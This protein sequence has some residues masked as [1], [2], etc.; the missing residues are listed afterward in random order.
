[1]NVRQRSP[2]PRIWL[3]L[4][5]VLLLAATHAPGV[6]A[7][8]IPERTGHTYLAVIEGATPFTTGVAVS[9]AAV[10]HTP[11]G[12]YHGQAG[13]NEFSSD[14]RSSFSDLTFVVR[15]SSVSGDEIVIHFVMTGT[16]T[17]LYQGMPGS[18]A[19]VKV[20]GLAVLTIG[21]R[22]ISEQWITYDQETLVTQIDRF[23]AAEASFNPDCPRFSPEVPVRDPNPLCIRRDHCRSDH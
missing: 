10:L 22:G 7:R 17:G 14:L 21:E 9:P 3:L 16:H 23:E 20:P 4:S 2:A 6:S 19:G 11:E 1:M 5:F 15:E 8:D 12:I 18:C 13:V